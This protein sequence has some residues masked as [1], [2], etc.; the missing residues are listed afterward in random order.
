MHC[1]FC[2]SKEL[3]HYIKKH[4]LTAKTKINYYKCR[5]CGS[6]HQFPTPDKKVINKY[7]DS[8]LKIKS[9]M[10]PGYLTEKNLKPFFNERD[11]TLQEIG[12]DK[13]LFENGLNVELGCATGDFLEY[14]K[15]NKA[16]NI[17]GIDVSAAHVGRFVRW[18]G[19]RE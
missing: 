13:K 18:V 11:L 14:M 9:K 7:Y 8:Y 10:N 5:K 4:S 16:K 12:F 15:K 17:I 3:I 1:S 19:S 2:N 6:F